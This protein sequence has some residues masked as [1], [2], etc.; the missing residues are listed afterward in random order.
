MA[1]AWSNG[2]FVEWRNYFT[3]DFEYEQLP[4]YPYQKEVFW[5]E[6]NLNNLSQSISVRKGGV[7]GHPLLMRF[8]DIASDSDVQF[9]E[10]ELNV[11]NFPYLSDH[12]VH[13]VIVFPA[14]GYLEM[15]RAAVRIWHVSTGGLL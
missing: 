10:T 15:G 4:I 5:M 8:I 7:L 14:A 3:H 1:I 12:K 9:W 13:D 11:L 6:E 2:V